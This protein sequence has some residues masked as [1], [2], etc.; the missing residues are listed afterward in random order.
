MTQTT[1]IED[2]DDRS[3]DP[4]SLVSSGPFV[5]AVP[6][7]FP[8]GNVAELVALAKARPGAVNFGSSGNATPLHILGEMMNRQTGAG[9]VHVPYKGP[10]AAIAALLAGDVQAVIDLY[11]SFPAHVASGRV[12]LLA[13]LAPQRLARIPAVPTAAEAGLPG[14]EASGWTML[15]APAGTGAAVIRTLNTAVRAAA[16]DAGFRDSMS[17]Q[18]LDAVPLSPAE[19]AAFLAAEAARWSEAVRISGARID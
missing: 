13:V 8:A 19:S 16:A 3:F 4:V 18:G 5:L 12:R 10:P 9:M 14:F 7:G 17:R 1:H 2:L 15:V 11:P 6:A